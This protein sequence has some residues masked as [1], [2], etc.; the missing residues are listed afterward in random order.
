MGKLVRVGRDKRVE[1]MPGDFLLMCKQ[2][3]QWAILQV[4][5]IEWMP[6]PGTPAEKIFMFASDYQCPISGKDART[7][8]QVKNNRL[9]DRDLILEENIQGVYKTEAQAMKVASAMLNASISMQEA[10]KQAHDIF[11]FTM[12]LVRT[13]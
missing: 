11:M 2:N 10:K 12:N 8:I 9:E 5:K 6:I 3:A 4:G 1:V 7:F 13:G